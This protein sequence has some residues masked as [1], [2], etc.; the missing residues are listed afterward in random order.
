MA[1]FGIGMECWN[2]GNLY[3]AEQHSARETAFFFV[4]VLRIGFLWPLGGMK[5]RLIEMS[6]NLEI[7]SSLISCSMS[8]EIF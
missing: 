4:T 7:Q 2:D 1:S 5:G 3:D 6:G 8:E